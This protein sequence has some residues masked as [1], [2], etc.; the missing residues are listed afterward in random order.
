MKGP[1][2]THFSTRLIASA[3]LVLHLVWVSAQVNPS[4]IEFQVKS[5][6]QH[7]FEIQSTSSP[8]NTYPGAFQ[9]VVKSQVNPSKSNSYDIIYDAPSHFQG[10]VQWYISYTSINPL[11]PYNVITNQ[12]LVTAHVQKSIIVANDVIVLYQ[13]SSPMTI[14]PLDNDEATDGPLK[15][16]GIANVHFG[17]TSIV[18]NQIRYTP[19]SAFSGRD[20]ITY[21]AEDLLKT[22]ASG[23]VYIISEDSEFS[24]KDKVVMTISSENPAY[25]F[26]PVQ[27]MNLIS[28]N[29]NRGTAE[30]R[31]PMAW[32]YNP[33]PGR[34]GKDILTFRSVTGKERIFEITVV[35]NAPPN[36]LVRDDQVHTAVNKKVVFNVL[37]N[38]FVKSPNIVYHSPQLQ[39]LGNGYFSYTPPP[40]FSGFQNFIYRV[41]TGAAILTG[42]ISVK[43]DNYYPE[44]RTYRFA[45]PQG[46]ELILDYSVPIEGYGFTIL[47]QPA[48]GTLEVFNTGHN[49]GVYC[50]TITSKV[51]VIYTPNAQFTGDDF[52]DLQYCID[53]KQCRVVKSAIKVYPFNSQD[54]DCVN[55]CVWPGDTDR[56][57]IVNMADLLPIGYY[58]GESGPAR[59]DQEYPEWNKQAADDWLLNQENGANLKHVDA[60]GNGTITHADTG[61]VWTHLFKTH[62]YIPNSVELT[63]KSP[64]RLIPR[65]PDVKPG[66]ILILDIMLGDSKFPVLDI[67]GL[68]FTIHVDPEFIDSASAEIV[69]YNDSWLSDG[70]GQ[71]EKF[72][73]PEKGFLTAGTTLT[74]RL[75]K[76]GFG[77]I[78]AILFGVEEDIAGFRKRKGVTK[79]PFTLDISDIIAMDSKGNTYTMP[80]ENAVVFLELG[81]DHLIMDA[82]LP[83]LN[84]QIKVYPN[85]ATDVIFVEL[86]AGEMIHQLSIFDGLGRRILFMPNLQEAQM[87]IPVGQFT[88]GIYYMEVHSQAER[89]TH[90][91]QI[92]K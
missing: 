53:G 41:N 78:G 29:G 21:T 66:E 46:R 67:H 61:V 35:D 59:N 90:K 15:L 6:S 2:L 34:K 18:G 45:T 27:G 77:V 19:G 39:N 56:N 32:L 72:V 44:N 40:G 57:G 38:D 42:K 86:P 37:E 88:Q 63:H 14:F 20:I 25:L 76:S 60:D 30:L 64:L 87:A 83:S 71:I 79:I 58:M 12:V 74:T 26:L 17:Y 89:T 24:G 10:V 22:K 81:E 49:V 43:V 62:G 73:Q 80:G 3:L 47:S 55:D 11:P 68:S 92:G 54:C 65:N 1:L 48:H 69:F 28:Q 50:G 4:T 51:L 70:F 31:H 13:G 16:T 36:G 85:P 23:R 7:H 8:D 75:P 84:E 33:I 52:F 5:G 9:G 91:I 82:P